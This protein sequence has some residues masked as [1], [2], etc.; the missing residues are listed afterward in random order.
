MVSTIKETK[1]KVMEEWHAA[2]DALPQCVWLIRP[3][4]SVAYTNKR[5]RDYTGTSTEQEQ[6]DG[7][8]QYTHPDDRQRVLLVWQNAVQTGEPYEA[9]LRLRQGTTGA[10]RWFLLQ[11][12][13]HKDSQ[14]TI[15]NYVG[16]CADIEGQK[17]AEQQLKESRE[18]WRVL[19]ETVPQL[20]WTTSSDGLVEY[21][22]RQWYDYTGSSP[23]QALGDGWSQFLHPDEYQH[24]LMVWHQALE[25]GE[26]Y[27]RL[28]EGQTGGYRWFLVRAMPVRDDTRQI[29]KWFGTCTDIDDQKRTEEALRLSQERVN[30]LMNSS[31]IGIFLAEDDAIVDANATFLQ[32]TGYRREDLQQRNVRW[33]TMTRP[34]A[35]SFSHQVYQDVVAQHCTTPFETELVCKDGSHLPVLLGGVAFHD[36]VLQGVGFVLDNSARQELDQR[37]DAFL[38]MASHE[39]K[40]PLASLK[41]QTQLLCK[42]L[43]KQDLSNVEVVCARMEGQLNA[44]TRLVDELL[45]LSRIQAGKLE[46]AHEMVDLDAMLKEVMD[47]LQHIQTTHTIVVQH[48]APPVFVVGDRDRLAQVF[49]NVLSNAIKYA[50]DAPQIEVTLTTSA[51][52]VTISIRDQGIGIPR[53]LQGRIFERF[54]RAV[55][56]QQRAFPG[57]G[58][59]LYIV[60]EIVKHHGGTIRVESE[61]G[62][63]STFHI[64]FP[65][66]ASREKRLRNTKE[67]RNV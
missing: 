57:L 4:G 38:G 66:A 53:E 45:D 8:L 1:Y 11:A 56:L 40:T 20:V 63:G 65:L 64:T 26:P 5:W 67:E 34:P 55:P 59:G 23:E 12:T 60:S 15:L 42:K 21:W 61:R 62:K 43:G 52:A 31:I 44:I 17:R 14:G 24:T 33:A 9:E 54:Y 2:I 48:A 41:L 29:V 3:D 18:N 28:K 22:N 47:V 25:T 46:Y 32:M 51:E 39:L 37:K 30:L 58:M 19:A 27:E 36:Q 50:P 35:A 10:Y 6:G 13:S 7:W 49:L 16:T